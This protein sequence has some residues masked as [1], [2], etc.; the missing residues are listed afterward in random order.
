VFDADYIIIGAGL[1][2][3]ATAY[4][5]R[6]RG[7]RRVIVLER[8]QVPGEHASG[9]NA[10]MIRSRIEDPVLQPLATEGAEI[11]CRGEVADFRRVGS[12]LIGTDD[13]AATSDVSRLVPPA[14]GRGLFTPDDG[15]IDV[16]A[17][18]QFYLRDQDLRLAT[19]VRGW[20]P[21]ASGVQV[22]TQQGVLSARVLVNAAGA[23]AGQLGDLD[24][25]PLVRHLFV[26]RATAAI[27]P[28]WPFVWD[29]DAGLYFRP[30]SGGLLLCAC[31]ETETAPG[32]Y[33]ERWDAFESLVDKVDRLQPGLRAVT[34]ELSI[35]HRWAGQRT[36]ALDRRLVIGYDRRVPV[37][38]WVA[39]LGG[40]G[41]TASP[42]IGRLAADLLIAGPASAHPLDPRRLLERADAA[43]RRRDSGANATSARR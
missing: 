42:A 40:H 41:V 34:H 20:Q 27:D 13:P 30:E 12:V 33:T 14:S 28:D 32:D 38:F 11:L 8:E 29:V 15:V 37:L 19:E 24:M 9:R 39:G 17:L 5:L 43:D 35:E 7:E 36:F 4:Q 1:A 2:G 25:R 31:D 10:A 18:L 26:T 22:E 3:A 16:A 21:T 23:W 6:Q